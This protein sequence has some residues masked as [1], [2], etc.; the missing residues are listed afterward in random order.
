VRVKTS[1]SWFQLIAF[2]ATIALLVALSMAIFFAG[3]TFA[4]ALAR[5]VEQPVANLANE[6]SA[7]V[8]NQV[9]SADPVSTQ[10][11]NG[12]ITD[13]RCNARHDMGS[14]K[15]P[16]ECAQACV[17][18]GAQY[19]LVDGDKSYVLHGDLQEL[20]KYSGLRVNLDGALDGEMIKVASIRSE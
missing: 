10:T 15:S 3:A 11:F 7:A 4:F 14:D 12:V 5:T 9:Q 8:A 20:A 13:D 16:S 1:R 17:R 18:N 2:S 6:A 19:A